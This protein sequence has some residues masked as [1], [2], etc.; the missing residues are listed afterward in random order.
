MAGHYPHAWVV[1]RCCVVKPVH[2]GLTDICSPAHI[3]DAGL[4][5]PSVRDTLAPAFLIEL[6]HCDER[7]AVEQQSIMPQNVTHSCN[8]EAPESRR[9]PFVMEAFDQATPEAKAL[10]A[11]PQLARARNRVD[12]IVEGRQ[13]F[14]L[15]GEKNLNAGQRV[16]IVIK[17]EEGR[18]G[19][20]SG[21]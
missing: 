20:P 14:G 9:Q 18:N 19:M 6:A 10:I 8:T 16:A 17:R 21:F 4:I 7:P 2:E 13:P 5:I 12:A 3:W 15:L 11:E 1:W